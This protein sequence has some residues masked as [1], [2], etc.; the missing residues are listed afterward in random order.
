MELK[1]CLVYALH[2]KIGRK[3]L[4]KP[5]TD[6]IVTLLI[7]AAATKQKSPCMLS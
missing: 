2:V 5:L 7:A 1:G 3:R 6:P 4:R